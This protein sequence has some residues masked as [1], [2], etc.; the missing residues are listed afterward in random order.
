M[1]TVRALPADQVLS[2]HQGLTS[3]ESVSHMNM[4]LGL[5]QFVEREAAAASCDLGS[6][7][8]WRSAASALLCMSFR[9][10]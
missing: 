6:P 8:L 5:L 9:C 3:C 7:L 4:L 10:G 1:L 2:N